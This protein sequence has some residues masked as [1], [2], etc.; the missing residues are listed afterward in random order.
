LLIVVVWPFTWHWECIVSTGLSQVGL[1]LTVITRVQWYSPLERLI[2]TPITLSVQCPT[3]LSVWHYRQT[4]N[5]KYRCRSTRTQD[6][7]YFANS[8]QSQLVPNTKSYPER[9]KAAWIW[10]NSQFYAVSS[11][12]WFSYCL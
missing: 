7:S 4:C 5:R 8:Y 12:R 11:Y 6:N 10:C 3:S 2:P 1:S 9:T